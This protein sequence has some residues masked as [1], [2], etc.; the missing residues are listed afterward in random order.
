[1]SFAI[2]IVAFAHV[3]AENKGSPVATENSVSQNIYDIPGAVYTAN[4][5]F[6]ASKVFGIMPI[7][8]IFC[9]LPVQNPSEGLQAYGWDKDKRNR[10]DYCRSN[11]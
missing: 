4:T 1:M 10:I 11:C 9:A 3:S 8:F 5:G 2:G 7:D 6:D